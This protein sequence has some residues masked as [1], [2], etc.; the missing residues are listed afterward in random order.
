MGA[1]LIVHFTDG[2]KP[3]ASV[4]DHWGADNPEDAFALIERFY[5]AVEEQTTDSRYG[6]PSYLAAKFLVWRAHE[7]TTGPYRKGTLLDFLSVG[8]FP[9]GKEPGDVE[10][11]LTLAC[12][13]KGRPSVGV[14]RS[15]E[16]AH[17]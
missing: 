1:R 10:C 2:T 15:W 14:G 6:D 9:T 11:I 17:V 16:H 4:Y 8:I 7:Y 5:E 3:I 12:E 13:T